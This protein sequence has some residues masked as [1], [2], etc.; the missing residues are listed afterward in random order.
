MINYNKSSLV[1]SKNVKED[2]QRVVS[3]TLGIER[4]EASVKYLGLPSL[5]GRKK[6]EILGFIRDKVVGRIQSWNSKFLSRAGREIL[7]KNVI[8]S[9][10]TYAMSVFLLPVGLCEEIERVMNGY[11]WGCEGERNKGIRW[12]AWSHLCIPKKMGGMGFRRLR[13]FNLALLGKQAWHL[14][15]Q[16]NSLVAKLYKARYYPTSSYLEANIGSNPSF[17]WRSIIEVQSTIKDN[18]RWRVGD[19]KSIKIWKDPWLPNANSHFIESEMPLQLANATVDSLFE[20]TGKNWDW[21]I[22]SDLFV[23]KDRDSITKIPISV[24]KPKDKMIWNLEE[25]GVYTVKS[26]YRNI[27]GEFQSPASSI[28]TRMWSFHLPPK[29]KFFSGNFV[30]ILFLQQIL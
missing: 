1:F 28:W 26:C 24:S 3:E 7:L 16:P 15:Q 8:Q 6:K 5:V 22:L 21:D 20:L 4:G 2:S 23:Q 25:K 18:Y 13:E 27:M 19:G 12:K 29:V 30:Q 17:I 11:W 14:L 10:P 9:I